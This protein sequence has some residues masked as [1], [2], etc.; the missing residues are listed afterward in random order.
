M[1]NSLKAE[2]TFHLYGSLVTKQ[3]PGVVVQLKTRFLGVSVRITEPGAE[4]N[5]FW[6]GWSEKT[7]PKKVRLTLGL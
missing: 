6:L 3:G 5:N 2:T 4:E 1:I 7:Y